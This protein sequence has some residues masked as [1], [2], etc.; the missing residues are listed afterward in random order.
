MRRASASGGDRRGGRLRRRKGWAETFAPVARGVKRTINEHAGVVV[1][2]VVP[3]RQLPKT[4]SGKLQRYLLARQFQAGEFGS[5]L[6]ALHALDPASDEAAAEGD[7]LERSLLEICQSFMR[8][9]KIGPEDNIFELGTSSLTLAQIY[10]RLEAVYPGK[11]EVTDFFD[12]PTVRSLAGYL[13][14]RL[15]AA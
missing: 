11:L 4:T 15:Q 10:E 2:A 5:T 6:E 13:S 14:Q 3:V 12:Y 8:D 1:A 9:K 7:G